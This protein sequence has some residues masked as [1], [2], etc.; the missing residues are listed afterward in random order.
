MSLTSSLDDRGSL[1]SQFMAAE[2]PGLRELQAAYRARR[3]AAASALRAEP[4]EGVRPAW[5]TL[6][7]AIDH[8]LRYAFAD[9]DEP[10]SA[11]SAGMVLAAGGSDRAV[12]AAIG[13]AAI[14][15]RAA[16]ADLVSGDRPS[17]RAGVIPL[18]AERRSA[19]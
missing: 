17:V 5:G 8:R 12:T 2:L 11:V 9:Q 16:L 19:C 1:V 10:S 14:G 7:Q 4:P 15:L 18:A 3:P 13:L 6:G